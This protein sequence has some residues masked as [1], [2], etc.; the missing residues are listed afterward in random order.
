DLGFSALG[1]PPRRFRSYDE[2][3][4]I[5]D[6]ML[7]SVPP[8]PA[9][10]YHSRR[11]SG[12]MPPSPSYRSDRQALGLDDQGAPRILAQPVRVSGEN[13]IP[14]RPA[15]SSRLP[16]GDVP[17]VVRARVLSPSLEPEATGGGYGFG[18]SGPR[19]D[20]TVVGPRQ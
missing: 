6:P 13:Y 14:S 15:S 18:G 8:S 5:G 16:S 9:Q 4:S 11:L 2:E 10:S 7:G 20:H 1:A 19:L 12:S 3:G 17:S